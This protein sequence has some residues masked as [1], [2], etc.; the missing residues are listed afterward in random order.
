MVGFCVN[1][2]QY[3]TPTEAWLKKTLLLKAFV[4]LSLPAETQ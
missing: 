4:I 2:F 3:L 1:L